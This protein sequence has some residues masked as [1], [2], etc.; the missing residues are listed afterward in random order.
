MTSKNYAHNFQA[1]FPQN[2]PAYLHP[3]VQPIHVN[4]LPTPYTHIYPTPLVPQPTRY[5]THL[6]PVFV[7]HLSRHQ[8]LNITVT[9]T[10]GKVEGKLAG[11][12][13]DHI[14]INLSKEKAIHIRI[15]EIVSFEGL[16]IS[17]K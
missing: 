14:Q 13:V 5:V 3:V 4:N 9:T 6:D 8:N 15:S 11:V 17:Y 1:Q 10:N 16:P 12:A 2:N 7:D